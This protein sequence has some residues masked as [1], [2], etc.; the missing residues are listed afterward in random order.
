MI[1]EQILAAQEKILL[2]H[3]KMQFIDL[4][5]P[6]KEHTNLAFT[7]IKNTFMELRALLEKQDV[8]VEDIEKVIQTATTAQTETNQVSQLVDKLLSIAAMML[9]KK[10]PTSF[11][12]DEYGR[13]LAKQ[14][15]SATGAEKDINNALEILQ[16]IL[17]LKK[18]ILAAQSQIVLALEQIDRIAK[19]EPQNTQ[20]ALTAITN[21]FEE[22]QSLSRKQD[23]SSEDIEKVIQ[24][25][26]K[27]KTETN[28]IFLLVDKLL[29]IAAARL[30][31]RN[32]TAKDS[33]KVGDQPSFPLEEYGPVLAKQYVMAQ[34]AEK[35]IKN[36]LKNLQQI[37]TADVGHENN[38]TNN[39]ESYKF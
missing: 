1:Q 12:I 24:T 28:K 31:Q 39:I 36:T 25:A 19:A 8:T 10:S 14:Y 11:P 35:H 17:N 37:F 2:A 30:E 13:L 15:V 9:E 4:T 32:S 23:F 22:I 7:A 6:S 16:R 34:T 38:N 33:K 20:L 27:A 26:T 5:E 21:T 3:K 18:Q 29:T